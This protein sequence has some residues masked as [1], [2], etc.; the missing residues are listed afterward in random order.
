MNYYIY[1]SSII[2]NNIMKKI[3]LY[4]RL[5]E[6]IYYIMDEMSDKI[7]ATTINSV[8][9]EVIRKELETKLNS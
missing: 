8:F 5:S 4:T 1:F 6:N 7:Y 2:K 9:A 3:R